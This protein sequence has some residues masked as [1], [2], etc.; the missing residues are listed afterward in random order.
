MSLYTW[1]VLVRY[2]SNSAM[3]PS[4]KERKTLLFPQASQPWNQAQNGHLQTGYGIAEMHRRDAIHAL[5]MA[6]TELSSM[7]RPRGAEGLSA[8]T[9]QAHPPRMC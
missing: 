9:A 2:L 6:K 1:M 4:F 5:S 8:P 3:L 7:R